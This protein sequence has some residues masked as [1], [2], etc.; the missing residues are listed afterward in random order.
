MVTLNVKC[1][2]LLTHMN[3]VGIH[4]LAT[5]MFTGAVKLWSHLNQ[6]CGIGPLLNSRGLVWFR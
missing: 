4:S 3:V 5:W 6:N 1:V 2:R